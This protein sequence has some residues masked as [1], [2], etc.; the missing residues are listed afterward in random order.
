MIDHT[1]LIFEKDTRTRTK[2]KLKKTG[3][4]LRLGRPGPSLSDPFSKTVRG[5]RKEKKKKKKKKKKNSFKNGTLVMILKPSQWVL[6]MRYNFY[7]EDNFV[8]TNAKE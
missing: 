7:N 5:K 4:T 2:L 1:R 8:N 6:K 3:R